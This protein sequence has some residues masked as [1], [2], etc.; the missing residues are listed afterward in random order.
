MSFLRQP[1]KGFISKEIETLIH[2]A[3]IFSLSV[4]PLEYSALETS[5]K[6]ISS[7]FL[8][9]RE[10]LMKLKCQHFQVFWT[11]LLIRYLLH[12]TK[13]PL[14]I[15][16]W[17]NYFD[18]ANMLWILTKLVKSFSYFRLHYK[19]FH[20]N[21]SGWILWTIQSAVIK[22]EILDKVLNLSLLF[23]IIRMIWISTS[24]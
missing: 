15:I 21:W 7:E 24:F 2:S 14:I 11:L 17:K 6:L 10:N 13:M 20:C 18:I 12:W 1:H 4:C 9:T 22:P 5:C 19:E 8:K 23:L 3:F 16:C